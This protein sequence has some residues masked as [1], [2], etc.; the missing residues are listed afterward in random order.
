MISNYFKSGIVAGVGL[1][2]L[3]IFMLSPSG[4]N[5]TSKLMQ[6]VNNYESEKR[7]WKI[8]YYLVAE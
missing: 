4:F 3:L 6:L 8:F 5:M 2:L 1:E 7:S